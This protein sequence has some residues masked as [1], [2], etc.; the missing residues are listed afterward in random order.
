MK[1]KHYFQY[2]NIDVKNCTEEDVKKYF[3]LANRFIKDAI[4]GGGKVFVHCSVLEIAAIMVSAYM[5]GVLKISL[6]QCL[7]KMAH[8]NIEISPHFLKQL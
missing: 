1:R 6:K 7:L 3:R 8:E 5:I 4:D 2:C